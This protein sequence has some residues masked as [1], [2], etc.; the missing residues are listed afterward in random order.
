MSDDSA[1]VVGTQ[2]T[3]AT[4]ATT[5]KSTA[6]LATE[7]DATLAE[8]EADTEDEYGADC[9]GGQTP[10][11]EDDKSWAEDVPGEELVDEVPGD[12]SGEA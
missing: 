7:P 2:S 11:F 6:T 10:E 1:T 8:A 12:L 4:T 3:L 9:E 5:A